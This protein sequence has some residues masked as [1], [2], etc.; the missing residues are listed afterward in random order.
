MI[1]DWLLILSTLFTCKGME[2]QFPFWILT[3]S[4][5]DRDRFS[6]SGLPLPHTCLSVT[7]EAAIALAGKGFSYTGAF[8][9]ISRHPFR[10][11]L[12]LVMPNLKARSV[13]PHFSSYVAQKHWTQQDAV[14]IPVLVCRDHG[15]LLHWQL[16]SFMRNQSKK[17]T[18]MRTSSA[19]N[20]FNQDSG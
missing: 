6:V 12:I 10:Q 11:V 7:R 13:T 15:L 8:L 5:L 16:S 18:E 20:W 19:S 17:N 1:H 4:I 9:T 14:S 2:Y 3:A